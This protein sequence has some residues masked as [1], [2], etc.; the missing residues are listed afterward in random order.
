MQPPWK[1]VWRL[2]KKLKVELP[3]KCTNFTTG[4]SS[5]ENENTNSK[6]TCT[7]MFRVVLFIIAKIW[8]KPMCLS[9][10]EW[11]RCEIYIH[12]HTHTQTHIH[13]L[14]HK[15]IQPKKKRMKLPVATMCMDIEGSMLS[16][17]NQAEKDK[18]CMI[19]LIRGI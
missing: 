1:G 3:Y 16:E 12:I 14:T 5:E 11:K 9:R 19:S 8:K 10:D 13:T 2:L 17:I 4:Y 6:D 15:Y 18:Y 7:P